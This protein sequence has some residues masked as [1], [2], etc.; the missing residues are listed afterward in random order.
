M[1]GKSPEELNAEELAIVTAGVSRFGRTGNRDAKQLAAGWAELMRSKNSKYLYNQYDAKTPRYISLKTIGLTTQFRY[2]YDDTRR[3]A[4]LTSGSK[5]YV[6]KNGSDSLERGGNGEKLKYE[7][8]MQRYPYISE[9]DATD[10][11]DCHS[12]YVTNSDYAV[13]LTG[14]MDGRAKE[15][16]DTLTG[17]DN[18]N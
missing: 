15:L 10:L 4:T 11:F 9:D 13:C 14:P 7:V 3:M 12:E 16:L 2:Y 18:S 1:F 5:A 17:D 6:F 8:V